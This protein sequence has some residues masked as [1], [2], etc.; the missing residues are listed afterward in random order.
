MEHSEDHELGHEPSVMSNLMEVSQRSRDLD[1]TP[2]SVAV[3]SAVSVAAAAMPSAA[4]AVL[5]AARAGNS[6][7]VV[8]PPE[9]MKGLRDGS[10]KLLTT[11]SGTQTATAVGKGSKFVANGRVVGAAGGGALSGA[12]LAAAGVVMLPIAIAALASYQQQQ[13]LERALADI[14]ATLDRIEERLKD[15]EHGVCEAAESFLELAASVALSG[16]LSPYL[17]NELAAHRARVEAVYFARRRYVHRFKADLERE[18]VAFEQKKG[19]RQ[20]WVD[21]VQ[22]LAKDGILQEE[23]ILFV[24]ALVAQSKLDTYAALCLADEGLAEAA[25]QLLHRSERE[26]RVEFFD[27]HNRLTPLAKIAPPRT[28]RDRVPL[29]SR[30][31]ERAHLV[32]QSLVEQLNENVLPSIPDPDDDRPLVIEL[33]AEDVQ[34]VAALVTQSPAA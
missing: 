25:A 19:E 10:L 22:E 1:T 3:L 29:M 17:R 4:D 13:Q 7:R 26:L 12:T 2:N 6:L 24:R 5:A 27:L 20:P 32:A 9:A 18:Q 23:L 15:E 30:G 28:V 8:F 31:V 21:S 16:P 33:S 11:K 14:Q 34:D